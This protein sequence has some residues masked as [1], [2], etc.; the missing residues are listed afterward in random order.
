[1]FT[2]VSTVAAGASLFVDDYLLYNNP[3]GPLGKFLPQE[4]QKW[5]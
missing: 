4:N 3:T 2:F 5:T 1:M